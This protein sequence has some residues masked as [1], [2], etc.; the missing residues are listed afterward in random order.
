MLGPY[1]HGQASR[2]CSLARQ[3][4]LALEAH[5][6]DMTWLFP[7]M[8]MYTAYTNQNGHIVGT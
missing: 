2:A 4:Q 6:D 7:K 1:S 5:V 8:R 3:W